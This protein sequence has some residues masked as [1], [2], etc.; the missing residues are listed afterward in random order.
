M[1][2]QL[3]YWIGYFDATLKGRVELEISDEN[4]IRFIRGA[5]EELRQ[6]REDRACVARAS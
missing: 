3:Q 5:L 1:E 2:E 6:R 4:D